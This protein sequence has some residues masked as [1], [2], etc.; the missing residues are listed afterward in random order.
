[1][2]PHIVVSK[3]WRLLTQNTRTLHCHKMSR[4]DYP[5]TLL[6]IP[7]EHNRQPSPYYVC[8]HFLL[9]ISMWLAS[10]DLPYSQFFSIFLC[11]E[12]ILHYYSF[13]SLI[14]RTLWVCCYCKSE[15]L[16]LCQN[17]QPDA[18]QHHRQND[19]CTV[20]IGGFPPSWWR[21]AN[22]WC[23]IVLWLPVHAACHPAAFTFRCD[24]RSG[25]T[26]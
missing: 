9:P 25:K 1:M 12:G 13:V 23:T 26:C 21:C 20:H 10:V 22:R 16:F 11:F 4:T 6:H 3:Q 14:F 18:P 5:L 7:E 8:G 17:I 24:P 19:M 15:Y 2:P